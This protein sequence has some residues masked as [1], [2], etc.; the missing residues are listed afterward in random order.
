MVWAS[1]LTF[2][3][4]SVGAWYPKLPAGVKLAFTLRWTLFLDPDPVSVT[5]SREGMA[6]MRRLG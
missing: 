3:R 2:G 6:S 1:R 5:W 4:A